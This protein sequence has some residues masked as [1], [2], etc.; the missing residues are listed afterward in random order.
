[1]TPRKQLKAY[2]KRAQKLYKSS[3]DSDGLPHLSGFSPVTQEVVRHLAAHPE[4]VATPEAAQV[5]IDRY[6]PDQ[7][8]T[9]YSEI[10][11]LLESGKFY[12]P[13]CE[14]RSKIIRDELAYVIG[15]QQRPLPIGGEK[16]ETSPT[17]P[18]ASPMESIL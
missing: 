5:F 3:L 4:N 12:G 2:L 9:L 15:I 14:R 16:V 18:E 10:H 1:V 6:N 8:R 7:Q 13:T 11:V 17:L